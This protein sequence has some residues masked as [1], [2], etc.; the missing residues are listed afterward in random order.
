M[1]LVCGGDDFELQCDTLNN[2]GML[3]VLTR[4]D[5]NG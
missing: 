4:G 3:Q 2:N 1:K 5:R